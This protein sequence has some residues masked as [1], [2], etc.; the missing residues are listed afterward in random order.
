MLPLRLLLAEP[1][2]ERA[3]AADFL[4][5]FVAPLTLWLREEE[6]ALRER[7]DCVL[8]APA[9]VDL[10]LL[11]AAAGLPVV[12]LTRTDLPLL[13][14]VLLDLRAVLL[15]IFAVIPPVVLLALIPEAGAVERLFRG[16]APSLSSLPLV[17]RIAPASLPNSSA[18]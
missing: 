16:R 12:D 18:L 11:V 14:L 7:A 15:A 1:L 9:R 4:A 5:V 6:P 2:R 8:E 10:V 13:D 17:S 3:P